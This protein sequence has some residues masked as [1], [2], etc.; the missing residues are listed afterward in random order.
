MQAKLF[1]GCIVSLALLVPSI[2]RADEYDDLLKSADKAILERDFDL[3]IAHCNRAIAIDRKFPS[4]YIT[5][6][7]AYSGKEDYDKCI[8]DC[9]TALALRPDAYHQSWAYRNR[10]GAYSD[11]RQYEQAIK[12]YQK[13]IQIQPKST[14]GYA[15]LAW[16][17]ATCPVD[18]FRDGK[19]A[20]EYANKAYVLDPRD[21]NNL[22]NLA[23]AYAECGDFDQAVSWQE[24]ALQGALEG[25]DKAADADDSSI[26][27]F[28]GRLDLYKKK[29]PYRTK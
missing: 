13:A 2:L 3:G 27:D 19:K 7:W 24:K 6:A 29:M 9:S 16:L 17:L 8:E 28:R 1:L 18:K 21:A 4:A 25:R 22:E 14:S 26:E 23:A 15:G 10:A 11:K 12:D 20:F 5:R